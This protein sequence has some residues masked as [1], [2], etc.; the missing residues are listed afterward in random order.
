MK[1]THKTTIIILYVITVIMALV[2]KYLYG[3]SFFIVLLLGLS[4][5]KFLLVA[6]QF[7]EMKK[8]HS[9]WKFLIVFYLILFVGAVSV[10]LM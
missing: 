9:A 10:I 2:S 4:A 7:M 8:A 3:Q 1:L 5:I 6:F